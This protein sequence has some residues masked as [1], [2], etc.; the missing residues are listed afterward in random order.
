MFPMCDPKSELDF[1]LASAVEFLEFFT[2]HGYD[3]LRQEDERKALFRLEVPVE[4]GLVVAR[5]LL[6]K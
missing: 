6:E 4:V 1:R 3:R 5:A 2:P